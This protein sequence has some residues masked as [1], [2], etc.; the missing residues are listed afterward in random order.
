MAAHDI[1]GEAYHPISPGGEDG[2]VDWYLFLLRMTHYEC[3]IRISPFDGRS[4]SFLGVIVERHTNKIFLFH[5]LS[6]FLQNVLALVTLKAPNDS[7]I[8]TFL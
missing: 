3:V 4:P 8:L 6:D 1:G 7:A 2:L 5:R